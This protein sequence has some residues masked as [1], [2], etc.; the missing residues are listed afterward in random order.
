MFKYELNNFGGFFSGEEGQQ[1]RYAVILS[2][3]PF[4]IR[5]RAILRLTVI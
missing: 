2:L 1:R 3:S 4:F 5:P